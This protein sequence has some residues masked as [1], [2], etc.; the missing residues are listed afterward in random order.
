[1]KELIDV[2]NKKTSKG[3]FDIYVPLTRKALLNLIHNQTVWCLSTLKGSNYEFECERMGFEDKDLLF[4]YTNTFVNEDKYYIVINRDQHVKL[5]DRYDDIIN[6]NAYIMYII[7]VSKDGKRWILDNNNLIDIDQ[8]E[9]ETDLKIDEFKWLPTPDGHFKI[10]S[11]SGDRIEFD[12]VNGKINNDY[13]ESFNDSDVVKLK[14]Q[15][16]NGYFDGK[17]VEYFDNGNVHVEHN[18]KNGELDGD[19]IVYF[20]DGTLHVKGQFKKGKKEGKVTIYNV[21]GNVEEID[22]YKNDLINGEC[23]TYYDNGKIEKVFHYK[24]DELDGEFNFYDEDGNLIEHAFYKNG[25]RIK[26][27]MT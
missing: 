13:I 20:L 6:E 17:Y 22:N 9:K 24:D 23:V 27:H 1:M 4:F 14:I 7:V 16:K 25:K 10:L 2:G 21:N 3:N 5:V 8:F 19:Y 15:M 12:V 11:L 18:Y 26:F